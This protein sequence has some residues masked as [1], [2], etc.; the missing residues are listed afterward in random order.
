MTVI[1]VGAVGGAGAAAVAKFG[2][3]PAGIIRDG[4]R[5]AGMRM[6]MGRSSRSFHQ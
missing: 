4:V 1:A 6:L 5:I 3:A 2:Q